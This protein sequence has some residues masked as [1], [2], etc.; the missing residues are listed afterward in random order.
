MKTYWRENETALTEAIIA[1]LS[2]SAR[3]LNA[4]KYKENTT[5]E[6]IAL[7]AWWSKNSLDSSFPTDAL[8]RFSTDYISGAIKK[9]ANLSLMPILQKFRIF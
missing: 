2:A 7:L 5:L 8:L 4:N 3:Q 6:R 9:A 1:D